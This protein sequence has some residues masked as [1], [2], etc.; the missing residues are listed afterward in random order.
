MNP[1]EREKIRSNLNKIGKG[2]CLAKWYE[3][4]LDLST[5][6][7]RSCDLVKYHSI[8]IDD[9]RSNHAL[10]HNSDY[11]KIQRYF[12]IAGIQ[13][14]EC[15]VCWSHETNTEKESDRLKKSALYYE[16]AD[17][18]NIVENGV[19]L[20]FFPK[21]IKLTFSRIC[22]IK[23]IVDGP[24]DS[25]E[26]F[27]EVRSNGPFIIENKPYNSLDF[28]EN[29]SIYIDQKNNPYIEIFWMWFYKASKDVDTLILQGGEPMMDRNFFRM[30]NFCNQVKNHKLNLEIISYCVPSGNQWCGFIHY[31]KKLSKKIQGISLICKINSW[32]PYLEYCNYGVDVKRLE[33]NLKNFLQSSMK[34]GKIIFQISFH[35]LS[36]QSLR[37]IMEFILYL[38]KK[39][40]NKHKKT[41]FFRMEIVSDPIFLH[42]S[43]FKELIYYI[44]DT[45]NF[46]KKNLET[47]GNKHIGFDQEEIEVVRLLQKEILEKNLNG[48]KN[49]FFEFIKQYDYRT[50]QQFNI[51]FRD[52]E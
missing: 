8:P 7:N 28:L 22:N 38:R 44:D 24:K 17:L 49:S 27:D 29:S 26:W 23:S 40:L 14:K 13:P 15:A 47:K 42:P 41:I 11:K 25:S 36:Y 3:L 52:H 18:T 4:D 37:N 1:D 43:V 6:N 32:G 31:V 9:L 48:F 21:K 34:N 5:G 45:I 16:N 30:M 50:N 10:F 12:M 51:L 39:F 35:A 46:M 33:D 20:D 19:S 2:F